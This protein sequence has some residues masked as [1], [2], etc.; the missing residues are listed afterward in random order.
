MNRLI[1]TAKMRIKEFIKDER[2]EFG[3]KQI[4]ATLGVII[5][6]GVAVGVISDSMPDWVGQA[7]DYLFEQIENLTSS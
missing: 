2:G 7:W 1:F 6:I 5:L 4:A 3:I